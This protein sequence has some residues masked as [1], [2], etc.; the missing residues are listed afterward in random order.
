M[1]QSELPEQLQEKIASTVNAKGFKLRK[2]SEEEAEQ[3]RGL[4]AWK[5]GYFITE[6]NAQVVLQTRQCGQNVIFRI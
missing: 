2:V 6:D 5:N 4:R 1:K 3:I